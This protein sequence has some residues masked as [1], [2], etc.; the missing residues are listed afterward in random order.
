VDEA[1]RAYYESGVEIGRL[2]RGYWRLEFARTKELLGRYLPA[3]R[4]RVLDVGGGPGVYAE[5]LAEAGYDVKLVDLVSLHVEHAR[6]RAAGRFAAEEGDARSLAEPDHSYDV[7]LLLGPLYH[8]V[9]RSDRLRAL[10][11]ARRVLHE[12]GLLA[13][14]AISRFGPLLDAL[15]RETFDERM[16]AFV[17]RALMDGRHLPARDGDLFT[18]A[19]FHLPD[20]LRDE[21]EEVGFRLEGLFGIEGPAW[22]RM[23]SL[24]ESEGFETAMRVA[25]AVETAPAVIGTSAH[26]FAVARPI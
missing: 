18:T 22:L 1:V 24:D 17:E 12:E 19:Y 4:A 6:R 13:A 7:V 26:L 3:A 23:E 16:W 14:A 21:V 9:E 5:W 11:E 8:L 25:R 2:D 10:S 15:A 20:E